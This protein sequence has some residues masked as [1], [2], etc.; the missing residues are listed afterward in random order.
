VHT[1]EESDRPIVPAKAVNEAKA[2]ESLEGRGR[3]KE[4]M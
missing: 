1:R 3:T 2:K 4:N